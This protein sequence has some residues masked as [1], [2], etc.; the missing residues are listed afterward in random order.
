MKKPSKKSIEK[1]RQACAKRLAL[2]QRAIGGDTDALIQAGIEI[3]GQGR[4]VN[5]NDLED[6]DDED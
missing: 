1:A 2:F 5:E 3:L 4:F 6:K